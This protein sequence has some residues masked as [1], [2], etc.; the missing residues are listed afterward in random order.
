M[1]TVT[2]NLAFGI[3]ASTSF[4]QP[5]LLAKRVSVLDHLKIDRAGWS[6]VAW[7]KFETIGLDDSPV[8]HDWRYRHADKY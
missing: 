3:T 2:R 8:E 6:V 1:A 5:F 7:Y 4:E